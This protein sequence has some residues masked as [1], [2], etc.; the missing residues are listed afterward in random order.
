MKIVV[1]GPS[2]AGKTTLC[3]RLSRDEFFTD[4]QTIGIEFYV[5]ELPHQTRRLRMVMWDVAGAKRHNV[6]QQRLYRDSDAVLLCFDVSNSVEFE[7]L[8]EYFVEV[9][10]YA[11]SC[12][13][14][15][16]GCKTDLYQQVTE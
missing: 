12:P 14:L 8:R 16:V 5:K 9:A 4:I 10:R 7:K 2:H 3:H 11:S 13:I 15:M 1:N 6:I